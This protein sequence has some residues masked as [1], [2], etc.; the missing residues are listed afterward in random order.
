MYI[1]LLSNVN[2]KFDDPPNIRPS[3][4]PNKTGHCTHFKG[5]L[6][7][8]ES[9]GMALWTD[10]V[11]QEVHQTTSRE[12]IPNLSG[13]LSSQGI[14]LHGASGFSC[15]AVVIWTPM[16]NWATKTNAIDEIMFVCSAGMPVVFCH[17]KP[18]LTYVEWCDLRLYSGKC[19]S[20][21]SYGDIQVLVFLCNQRQVKSILGDCTKAAPQS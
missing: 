2:R 14:R 9:H 20:G 5:W 18:H 1:D 3:A 16:A 19:T 7:D 13:L 15:N 17:R 6:W 21:L 10:I 11:S 4:P 12:H 8:P